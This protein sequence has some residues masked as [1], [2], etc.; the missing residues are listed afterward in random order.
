MGLVSK[1]FGSGA[2]KR[3]ISLQGN[4]EFAVDADCEANYQPALQKIAGHTPDEVCEVP[5]HAELVLEPNGRVSVRIGDQTV[6]YLKEQMAVDYSNR[7]ASLGLREPVSCDGMIV[8]GWAGH[9]GEEGTFGVK[10][11][12]VW[13][14]RV[15]GQ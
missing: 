8:G 5:C 14:I 15:A 10:L 7:A 6:G 11:D 3:L 13:P 4:G 12:L 9:D 2:R 1:L